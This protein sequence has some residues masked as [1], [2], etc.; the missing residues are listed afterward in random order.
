M[1]ET[2]TPATFSGQNDEPKL[3]QAQQAEENQ[4]K[5]APRPGQRPKPGR[6]PLFRT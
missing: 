2:K 6:K 1:T 4:A 5:A 3:E